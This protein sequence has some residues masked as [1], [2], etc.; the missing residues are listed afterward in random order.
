MIKDMELRYIDGH[1]HIQ[2]RTFDED[3]EA[4]LSRMEEV[5][6]GALVV[7]VDY[8]SSRRAVEVA[9]SSSLLSAVIGVH[10][11]DTPTEGF[12]P[13]KYVDL[14]QQRGVVG[15]GECGLEYFRMEDDNHEEKERQ[16]QLF[17][18]QIEFALEH[19]LPLML[20]CRP[21]PKTMDSYEDTLDIL[22]SYAKE[23]GERLRG[24]VHFFVGDI[25]IARRFLTIGF[26]LSF[27]GVL[28][29]AHDYDEVVR[30]A[31][32]D[33]ILA[34]TDSPY[35]APVP[36]RGKRNEPTYV[37]EVVA[38][39][40]EIRGEDHEVVREALINNARRVFGMR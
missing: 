38:R 6:V 9:S 1:C 3:R 31:P 12:E 22:E 33:M 21:T 35:V 24:N 18:A 7:G 36:H 20:H 5:G 25:D 28:T 11:V 40:A 19:D 4:I 37:Q 39:I 15:I 34:E 26:T 29:F 23:H 27:T 10:P 32:L 13:K 16:Q 30:F 8:A 14:I 2:E 17:C